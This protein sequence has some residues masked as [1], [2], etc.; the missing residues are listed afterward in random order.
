[1]INDLQIPGCE[2]FA[3]IEP[4]NKGTNDEKYYIET[5]DGRQL[6]LRIADGSK[7]E[8]KKNT[9]AMLGQISKL[10]ITFS[11]PV[12]IGL[13]NN[14]KNVYQLLTWVNG[15][16]AESVLPIS[17]EKEQYN[18]GLKSG[19]VLRQIHSVSAPEETEDWDIKFNRMLQKQLNEFNTKTELHFEFEEIIVGYFKKNRDKLGVRPQSLNHGDY[20]PGNII[21]MPNGEIGVIDFACSYG[22]PCYDI[23]Q[24]GWHPTQF[25]YFYSGLILG[26]CDGEPTIEYWKA[27]IH[28]WALYTFYAL[29]CPQWVGL[30]NLEN[31]KRVVRDILDWSDNLSNPIPKWYMGSSYH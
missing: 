30:D 7:Y 15:D 21:V 10:D 26:H 29:L 13:C 9:H 2:A 4:I 22:D 18:L 8:L 28:Y 16:D 24:A 11:R 19:R 12:K 20:N 23:S 27:Y 14:D 5:N 25:P 6:L 3:K 1:M 17:T 31:G